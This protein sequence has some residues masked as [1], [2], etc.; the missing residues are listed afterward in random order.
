[1]DA[2]PTRCSEVSRLG[3]A[4]H[5]EGERRVYM[6]RERAAR[7][8]I[9]LTTFHRMKSDGLD[10]QSAIEAA[11]EAKARGTVKYDKLNRIDRATDTNLSNRLLRGWTRHG[12][13]Q[14]HAAGE[15][16][17]AGERSGVRARGARY[18]LPCTEQPSRRGPGRATRLAAAG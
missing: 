2:D 17:V 6:S 8:G 10:V 15:S 1:M 16:T 3:Y 12:Q 5:L 18:G 9:S 4:H 7:L 11:Q 13:D 14:G